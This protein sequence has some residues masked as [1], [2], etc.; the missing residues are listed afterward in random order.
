MNKSVM[1]RSNYLFIETDDFTG[2]FCLGCGQH[3]PKVDVAS[4]ATYR[5]KGDLTRP[6]HFW[7]EGK[8]IASFGP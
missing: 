3:R 8:L 5:H 2:Y 1:H 6:K 7:Y 4:G